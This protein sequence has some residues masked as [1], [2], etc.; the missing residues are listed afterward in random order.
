MRSYLNSSL[1]SNKKYEIPF[2]GF[3]SCLLK[4]KKIFKFENRKFHFPKYKELFISGLF[5]IFEALKIRAPIFWNIRK[6]CFLKYKEFFRDFRFPKY[7]KS[8][9]LRKYKKFLDIRARMLYFGVNL[10]KFK[11]FFDRVFLY[12]S[13]LGLKVSSF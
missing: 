2:S 3:A 7:K 12:F 13:N 9:L 8:F 5:F 11:N 6:F 10:I 1:S 4:Y